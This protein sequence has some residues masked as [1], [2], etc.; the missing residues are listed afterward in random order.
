LTSNRSE[1]VPAAPTSATAQVFD[2]PQ[3]YPEKVVEYFD[4]YNIAHATYNLIS[5][6][7]RLH[8]KDATLDDA[9]HAFNDMVSWANTFL[10][11]IQ[12]ECA[13]KGEA[14][15]FA[16]ALKKLRLERG[17]SPNYASMD[18]YAKR[19]ATAVAGAVGF[20]RKYQLFIGE[21]PSLEIPFDLAR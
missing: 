5:R 14:E 8:Y 17:A 2:R 10:R 16:E 9:I 6:D 15:V 19:L 20:A 7:A 18:D 1:R 21:R 13:K 3:S 4:R 11:L 12:M